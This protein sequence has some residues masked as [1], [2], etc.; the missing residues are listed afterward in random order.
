MCF[1]FLMQDKSIFYIEDHD[2]ESE[3]KGRTES[4]MLTVATIVY[5]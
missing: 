1:Y 5:W 2:E 4:N 3:N